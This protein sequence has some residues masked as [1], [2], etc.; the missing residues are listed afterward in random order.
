MGRYILKQ[1]TIAV[2][3]WMDGYKMLYIQAEVINQMPSCM[4]EA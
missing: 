2:R 1:Q 4:L 3:L